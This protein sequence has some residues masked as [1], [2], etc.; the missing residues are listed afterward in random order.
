MMPLLPLLAIAVLQ[1]VPGDTLFVQSSGMNLRAKPK[2]TATI[3]M[4]VPIGSA[5]SVLSTT[6]DG[7]AELKCPQAKGFGKLDLLGPQ[8]PDHA[9]LLAQGKEA[10]RPLPD[11]LNLLQRAVTLKPDDAPTQEAFREFFWKAEFDRLARMRVK[12]DVLKKE[13]LFPAACGEDTA[14]CVKGALAPEGGM[15]VAWEEVR[16]QGSDVVLAQLFADGLFQLRSGAIDAGKRTVLVQLESVMVPTAAVVKAL[17]AGEVEDACQPA[18]NGEGAGSFCGYAYDQNCAPDDCWSPMESCK[19]AAASRC[20]DCKLSC[21]S[22]CG[23]CRLKCGTRNRQ[24]CVTSCIE[25]TRSC[26]ETCQAPIESENASCDAEYQ[27][28][29]AAAERE[30]N[31]TCKG[32]CDRVHACVDRC[33]KKGTPTWTCVERCDDKL[34]ESCSHQCLFGF[35]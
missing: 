6:P 28:C 18:I 33:Q 27:S 20:Q 1:A 26:E 8:A 5:C 16:V 17:G 31:R 22:T 3:R 30:W 2:A 12:N 24:A 25:A 14:N 19:E 13:G 11:A 7:W 15:K 10:G 34:P 32:P 9:Q 4:M 29:S 21:K 35:Q 23:D